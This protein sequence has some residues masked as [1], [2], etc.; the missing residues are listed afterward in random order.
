VYLAALPTLL[1]QLLWSYVSG[2]GNPLLAN[3][4]RALLVASSEEPERENWEKHELTSIEASPTPPTERDALIKA[5][6]G[7]GVF[8]ENVARVERACR[9]TRVSNPA[10]LIASH[11]KP[12][13]HSTNDERLSGHN[14]LMLAPQADF[15]F[16]RGFI[17]FQDGR[18]MVSPVADLKSLVKLGV[19]PERPPEVGSFG[20]AQEKYLEFHRKEIFRS[21]TASR[22]RV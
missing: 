5:R 16:D 4:E 15:L 9:I 21:A 20:Q 17:S 13:R 14:G 6:R 22:R 7:Q 19:D 2:D 10:Y 12:W 18:L 11:I 3:D 1:G 8:R